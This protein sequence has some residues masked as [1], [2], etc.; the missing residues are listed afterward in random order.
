MKPLVPRQEIS[1]LTRLT[2]LALD[3][4]DTGYIGE[5]Y[6]CLIEGLCRARR[7]RDSG[8]PW[9]DAL[10]ACYSRT[11]YDFAERFNVARE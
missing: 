9:G 1:A 6:T 10:L 7:L 4:A 2:A 5:G 11:V 8:E 3:M